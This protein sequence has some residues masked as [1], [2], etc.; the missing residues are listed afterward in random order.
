MGLRRERSMQRFYFDVRENGTFSPDEVGL[1]FPDLDAAEREATVAASAIARDRL[2]NGKSREIVM[3]VRDEHWHR[4]ST[5]TVSLR[6]ERRTFATAVAM[7]SIHDAPADLAAVAQA[8]EKMRADFRPASISVLFVGEAVPANGTFFYDGTSQMFREFKRALGTKLGSPAD[9]LGAFKA[10]GY[11]LDD[12][13]LMPMHRLSGT[14][15]CRRHLDGVP[16]LCTG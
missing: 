7:P 13:V 14:D 12:L 4:M 15:R 8:A 3:E 10:R 9:F 1:E 6:V 11:F 2:P 5:V 16:S